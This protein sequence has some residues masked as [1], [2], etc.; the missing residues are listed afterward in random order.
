M[1][2]IFLIVSLLLKKKLSNTLFIN[3]SKLLKALF[4][5]RKLYHIKLMIH[6]HLLLL[7]FTSW[8][9][10]FLILSYY[11]LFLALF[12][13]SSLLSSIINQVAPCLLSLN[14]SRE[15][16][17]I[18]FLSLFITDLFYICLCNFFMDF[19]PQPLSLTKDF[20][21]TF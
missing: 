10:S 21:L 5:L 12:L 1:N 13:L 8:S 11:S 20:C 16:K 17:V 6:F 4:V 14:N 7:P 18:L 19:L 15:N 2:E 9:S 3:D